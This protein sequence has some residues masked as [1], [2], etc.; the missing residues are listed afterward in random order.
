MRDVIFRGILGNDV[1]GFHSRRYARNF[2]RGCEALL[3][4]PVDLARL[5]IEVDGR[6]VSARWYPISVAPAEIEARAASA[7]VAEHERRL[8]E[9]RRQHLVVRADRADPS[10]NIVRG[11]RAFAT[12]LDDHP[13]LA[14]QV[15]FLALVQPSREDVGEYVEYLESIRRVVADVN[16]KYATDTWQPVELS[17]EGDFDEVVAAYRQFDVLMVNPIADGMNLVAK[18]ACLVN[19]G[20]VLVLSESAG[21]AEELGPFALTVHPFDIQQQAD[22]LYAGLTM[23]P[24]ERRERMAACAGVVHDNDVSKWLADQLEDIRRLR[25]SR[26]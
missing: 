2:V 11:F 8:V 13:E 25:Q 24:S 17:L 14:E 19:D 10:K 7:E 4:V 3:G 21:V 18:E 23:D 16:R 20:G 26:R 22:A 6:T 5:T 9:R 12:M 15:T 1:V